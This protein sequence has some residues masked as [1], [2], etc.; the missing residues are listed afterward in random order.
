MAYLKSVLFTIVSII[1]VIFRF[2]LLRSKNFFLTKPAHP[3]LFSISHS[4]IISLSVSSQ[5]S[6]RIEANKYN[7]KK[8]SATDILL[9]FAYWYL[10]H[11]SIWKDC[12]S[13]FCCVIYLCGMAFPFWFL[14]WKLCC[15][16][17]RI[18]LPCSRSYLSLPST[19]EQAEKIG[20]TWK[21]AICY[22][23]KYV[24]TCKLESGEMGG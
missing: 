24:I 9:R 17:L 19:A 1:L 10:I 4:I 23:T 5:I 11:V 13:L 8:G 16:L 21:G 12:V 2:I 7:W 14:Q 3:T 18:H 15:H 20:K 22:C 6:F